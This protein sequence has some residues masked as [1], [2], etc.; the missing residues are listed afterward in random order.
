MDE[1]FQ[2]WKEDYAR[3]FPHADAEAETEPVTDAD[4]NQWP[5]PSSPGQSLF[6]PP[7]LVPLNPEQII[8]SP[9]RNAMPLRTLWMGHLARI[10]FMAF[11]SDGPEGIGQPLLS[12]RTRAR[13]AEL[14]DDAVRDS[15]PEDITTIDG[16][17]QPR[18][19]FELVVRTVW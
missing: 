11:F 4:P 15:L 12:S 19:V 18:L 17:G 8:V 13:A 3:E 16:E 6:F 1:S 7:V 9:Y 14:W 5:P 2:Q 10:E